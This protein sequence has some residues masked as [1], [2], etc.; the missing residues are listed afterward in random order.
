MEKKYQKQFEEME[1]AS[2]PD[3]AGMLQ[4]SDRESKTTMVNML[5]ALLDKVDNMQE[6][7][8]SVNW[9]MEILIKNQNKC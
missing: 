5:M 8:A 7:M 6:Q 2:E 1:Q 3:M 4:L 9:E